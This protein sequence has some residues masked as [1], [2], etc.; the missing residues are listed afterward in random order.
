MKIK[1]H[2]YLYVAEE[3]K[4]IQLKRIRKP[5]NLWSSRNCRR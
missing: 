2:Y 4:I 1:D 3:T 5:L